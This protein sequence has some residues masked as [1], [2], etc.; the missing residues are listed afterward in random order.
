MT[1][2]LL[3]R[4]CLS[5]EVTTIAQYES[6]VA[7]GVSHTMDSLFWQIACDYRAALAPSRSFPA[8]SFR[9]PSAAPPTIS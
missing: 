2:P 1:D 3:G 8:A 9:R 7:C 5:W 4:K 6:A